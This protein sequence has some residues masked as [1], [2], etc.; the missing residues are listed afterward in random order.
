MWL[1]TIIDYV[2]YVYCILYIEDTMFGFSF[3]YLDGY[4]PGFS[5]GRI[6]KLSS[7]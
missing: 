2:D 4:E 1:C 3:M 5:V 7:P 6:V